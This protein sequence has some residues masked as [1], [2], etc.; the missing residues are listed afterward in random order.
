MKREYVIVSTLGLHARPASMLVKEANR[1]EN[2][3]LIGFKGQSFTLKSIMI[4]LSLGVSEGEKIT[5]EVFEPNAE[6]I[7]ESLENVMREFDLI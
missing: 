5:L 3:I 4:V 1:Y 2:E 6:V 7:L